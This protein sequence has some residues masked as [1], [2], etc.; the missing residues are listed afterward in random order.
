[1]VLPGDGPACTVLYCQDAAVARWRLWWWSCV[2]VVLC[3]VV[4]GVSMRLP[5]PH[6]SSPRLPVPRSEDRGGTSMQHFCE[7]IHKSLLKE[8]QYALVWGTSSKH[9]PQR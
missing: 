2:W 7:M 4:R 5:A 6:L 1:M 9:M 8:F 3:V